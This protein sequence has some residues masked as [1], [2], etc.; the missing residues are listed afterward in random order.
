MKAFKPIKDRHEKLRDLILS[1]FSDLPPDQAAFISGDES[2]VLIGLRQL[3]RNIFLIHQVYKA[4]GKD[5]FLGACS[6]SIKALE[7]ELGK[8]EAAKHLVEEYT[9]PR[10]LTPVKKISPITSAKAA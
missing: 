7:A 4:L 10:K 6:I 5:R 9:G 2:T 8:E 3:Q 1:W